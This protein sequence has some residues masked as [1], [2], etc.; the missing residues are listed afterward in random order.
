MSLQ[1]CV[2]LALCIGCS[3]A[4]SSKGTGD[5]T[6]LVERLA[7]ANQA[8]QPLVVEFGATWCKPCHD[9]AD[10]VLTDPRVQTALHGI[11]FVQYDVD[12]QSGADAA[13][14]CNVGNVPTVVAV[15]RD[16]APQPL[17]PGREPTVDEFVAFLQQI[18]A[19]PH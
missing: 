7:A 3:P 9:F 5:G 6:M 16:G 14:R 2:A 15:A 10:H 8:K 18:A 13:K 11:A 17:N 4:A 1:R 19:N 12:T